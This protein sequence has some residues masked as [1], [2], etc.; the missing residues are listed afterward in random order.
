MIRKFQP[1]VPTELVNCFTSW[2]HTIQNSQ[3][4]NLEIPMN[5]HELTKEGSMEFLFTLKEEEKL[6]AAAVVVDILQNKNY[7]IG[8]A[9]TEH[10]SGI[11]LLER[12][13][14]E[15]KVEFPHSVT[16]VID[17]NAL[18]EKKVLLE[19]GASYVVSEAQLTLEKLAIKEK[20]IDI[21]LAVYEPLL[22]DQYRSIL[23]ASFGD[24]MD[25][26]EAVIQLSLSQTN[27]TFYG[28]YH[29]S[30]LV[31]TINVIREDDAFITALSVHPLHQ[32]KG[33]GKAALTHVVT[34]LLQEGFTTVSLDVEVENTHALKLYEHVGFKIM[35]MFDFYEIKKSL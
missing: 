15:L 33:I 18:L 24:S 19:A 16:I 35:S 8:F 7:E 30:K 32:N 4:I 27:R 29:Q 12:I 13:G 2:A 26:A 10:H 31:G 1:P 6:V 17:K 3:N 34:M 20:L 11:K 21:E 14:N 25:A 23:M 28:I 5:L 22:H 9:A